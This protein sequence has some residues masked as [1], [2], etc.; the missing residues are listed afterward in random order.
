MAKIWSIRFTVRGI[1]KFPIDMLRYDSCYPAT[2]ED[3]QWIESERA[4]GNGSRELMLEHRSHGS[5]TWTPT[6]GRWQSFGWVVTEV[7][8]PNECR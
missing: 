5:R 4:A 7:Y 6:F 3:T 8:R 2:G 1:G